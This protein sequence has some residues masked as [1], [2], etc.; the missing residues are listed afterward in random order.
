MEVMLTLTHIGE[1]LRGLHHSVPIT[2]IPMP[3]HV[4]EC[5]L[6]VRQLRHI[7]HD[8]P[9]GDITRHRVNLM[10][11]SHIYAEIAFYYKEKRT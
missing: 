11:R 7:D 8:F 3:T 5:L 2:L 1:G 4:R 6:H 9:T 10:D